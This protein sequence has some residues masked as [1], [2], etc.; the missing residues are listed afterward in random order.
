[1]KCAAEYKTDAVAYKIDAAAYKTD[2]VADSSWFCPSSPVIVT[3]RASQPS[4]TKES[5]IYS[6][7][8][9]DLRGEDCSVNTKM[10]IKF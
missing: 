7:Q 5:A 3:S 8:D 6:S 9:L 10:S 4:S 1:M 2:A